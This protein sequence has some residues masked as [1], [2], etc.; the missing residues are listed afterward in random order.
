MKDIYKKPL[1]YYVLLTVL[2]GLWPLWLSVLGLPGAKDSYKKE[3]GQYNEAQKLIGEVL[4]LDSQRLDYAKTKKDDDAFDYTTA[5]DQVTR[6]CGI[7]PSDY[8]LSSSPVRKMKGGQ[9]SQD[10][11]MAI[12]RIDIERFAKFLSVIHMRWANLQCTNITLANIKG[13]RNV[14]KADVRFMYYQ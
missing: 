12:D 8:K 2:A 7:A 14:W 3:T 5:I 10:A 4:D 11:A 13:E 6:F 9:K 1:F